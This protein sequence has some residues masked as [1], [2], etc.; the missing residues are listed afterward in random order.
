MTQLTRHPASLVIEDQLD[1]IGHK[2]R[3]VQL[4]RGAMLWVAWGLF[5][6][7]ASALAAD[8][9]GQGWPSQCV[10][11]LLSAWLILSAGHWMARPLLARPSPVTVAR[12]VEQRVDGLYNGLS[13]T[14]LLGQAADI[15]QNPWLGPI[16]EEILANCRQRPLESAVRF[17]HLGPL[18]AR[19]GL[20]IGA[21]ILALVLAPARLAHGWQQMLT[22]GSFVPK[23]G[24]VQII[25][26]Q[27]GDVTLVTGQPLEITVTAKSPQTPPPRARVVFDGV[28]TSADLPA[29]IRAEDGALLYSYRADHVDGPLKY[30]VEVGGTQS[31]WYSVQI[32]PK[33][34]LTSLDVKITPPAY[35]RQAVRTLTL[36]AD[37]AQ[38][39][40]PQG[41]RVE[42]GAGID[43]AVKRAV[44]MIDNQPPVDMTPALAN[45]RFFR[46]I[47]VAG[48][49]TA[50]VGILGGDQII[51]KLPDNG[52]SIHSTP[53]EPPVVTMRW[54]SQDV[55]M[56][57][58]TDLTI[59]ADLRDD[60]GV[61]SARLL[62]GFGSDDPAPLAGSE[63]RFS[64]EP[65]AVAVQ[66][67]LKLTADQAKQ[68]ASTL[69]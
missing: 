38:V 51:A 36:T 35:T 49:E 53:D 25:D 9:L 56:P 61:R 15:A 34:T 18:G 22:P 65:A 41:S 58:T 40:V 1:A 30:R 5:A 60:Y 32:V 31:N 11:A 57:P 12:L 21:A 55:T 23:S 8:V 48:D 10:L 66:F 19:L 68:D 24:S 45:L 27:P 63:Q 59:S 50:Y 3:L 54:P 46:E 29:T 7:T 69:R 43:V 14:V 20:V 16:Y 42:I 52:L 28:L 64:G 39:A 26:V 62:V 47:T 67:P 17:S 6:A 44:L 13:N 33:V 4:V 2:H 37:H